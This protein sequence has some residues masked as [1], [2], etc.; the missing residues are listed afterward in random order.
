M[1]GLVARGLRHAF[2]GVRA[3]DDVDIV[4]RDGEVVGVIG[5]NGCGKTTVVDAVSGVLR[6]RAG[7]VEL[8]GR[9]VTGATP[10][11][12]A[13]AGLA[14]TFQT[15]RLL[16]PLDAVT[17]V[18]L[19]LHAGGSWRRRGRRRLALETLAAMGIAGLADRRVDELSHGQRR[20]VELAR[21]LV[22]SPSVL[23]LD[24]PT[25]GLFP[26]HA[27]EVLG[28]LREA[29]RRGCAIL[30]VEHDISVVSALCDRVVLMGDGRV[31]DA[32]P[33][34]AVLAGR[35][36]AVTR[37]DVSADRLAEVPA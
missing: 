29:A 16:E 4:V 18:T 21:A 15:T 5:P 30:L 33:T 11:V 36:A 13:R 2:G 1:S 32:G 6:P 19:G 20:R 24:E 3:L 7:R 31:L 22:G 12:M 25:A 14:R 37:A 26:G 9:D 8:N 35:A 17:N 28:V 23:L 27:R 10:V 34:A